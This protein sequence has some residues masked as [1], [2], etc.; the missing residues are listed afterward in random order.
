MV[1]DISDHSKYSAQLW[2]EDEPIRFYRVVGDECVGGGGGQHEPC[3]YRLDFACHEQPAR[4]GLV[5]F[6]RSRVDECSDALLSRALA[7][8]AMRAKRS[9]GNRRWRGNGEMGFL[10]LPERRI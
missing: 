2:R 4:G 6:Q 8:V 1:A 10:K 5:L 3:E 7:T 9:A